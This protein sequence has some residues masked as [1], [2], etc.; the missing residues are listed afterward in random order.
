MA[1]SVWRMAHVRAYVRVLTVDK[2][3]ATHKQTG[4]LDDNVIQYQYSACMCACKHKPLTR[5]MSLHKS[6]SRCQC[7]RDYNKTQYLG[8][9][10]LSLQEP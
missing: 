6:T 2:T 10:L 8:M 4:E 5:H 9:C 1:S 3:L 7:E